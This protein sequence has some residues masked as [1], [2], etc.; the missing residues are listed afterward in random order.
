MAW[1]HSKEVETHVS[2]SSN[3]YHWQLPLELHPTTWY[4]CRDLDFMGPGGKRSQVLVVKSDLGLS[5][6]ADVSFDIKRRKMRPGKQQAGSVRYSSHNLVR[7]SLQFEASVP[8]IKAR[9]R[10][11]FTF[12]PQQPFAQRC[13]RRYDLQHH[14]FSRHL[15]SPSRGQSQKQAALIPVS[16]PISS[17]SVL[18]FFFPPRATS[19]P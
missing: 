7:A 4:G 8:S 16:I 13:V 2:V 1:Y 19:D 9:L 15:V 11:V 18:S 5:R 3:Q 12:F 6:V 14:D 10:T 17:S